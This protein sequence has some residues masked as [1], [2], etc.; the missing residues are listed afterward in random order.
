MIKYCKRLLIIFI[1]FF[2]IIQ[3]V[4]AE[5]DVYYE[6]ISDGYVQNEEEKSYEEKTYQNEETGYTA[7]I[8]DEADLLTTE[9]EQQLLEEMIPLTE[10]GHIAFQTVIDNYSSTSY[11][12]EQRYHNLF[13]TSS[14][15]IF[16][17]DMSNR[18]IYLFSDG[19]NYRYITKSKAN[20]ITD[21][22]YRDAKRADY[23]GCASN[24]FKQINTILSGG[25]IV[26]PMR[27]IS[28]Y[29]IALIVSF[30]VD[31][32]IIMS[33]TKIAP[34]SNYTLL[35]NSSIEFSTG[36]IQV[37]KVGTHK[38]YSPPSDSGSGFSG[39]SSG[40]GGGGGGG[41]GS[42]GGGGGHGF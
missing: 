1:A 21:N 5:E 30:F 3:P 22:V 4:Y 19:Q 17:I 20:I 15:T 31:F 10:Y 8:F 35:K 38:V 9:Q 24:T 16:V 14:G 27:H 42:S 25:K 32:I 2:T 37:V 26:E 28:N 11:Y 18:Q 7:R 23:Y 12:S 29:I 36:D 40:G 33:K 39:G 6:E 13:G 34:A 41:G